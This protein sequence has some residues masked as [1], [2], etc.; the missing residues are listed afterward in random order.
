MRKI[1]ISTLDGTHSVATVQDGRLIEFS[2]EAESNRSIVGNVYKGRVVNVLNGMQA[3]FVDIGQARNAYLFVGESLVDSTALA[4][5]DDLEKSTALNVKP[6]DEIMVQVAKVATGLKGARVTA[7]VSLPGRNLVF[8]PFADYVGVSRKIENEEERNRLEE[9]MESL[10]PAGS[11]FIIRTAAEGIS[12][13]ELKSEAESLIAL[14]ERI[15]SKYDKI[16]CAQLAYEEGSILYRSVRDI[17]RSDVEEIIVDDEKTFRIVNAIMD[18]LVGKTRC[19]ITLEK[20]DTEDL[21]SKYGVMQQMLS[22]LSPKVVLS[23]GAYLI[24]ERTEALTVIDVNTGKYVGNKNLEETVFATNL[25][26][27]KEIAAQLRLRNIG[28]IIIVDFIDMENEEHKEQVLAKLAE[29]LKKDRIRTSLVGMTGLGLV[30]ITRKKARADLLERLAMKCPHC[31]GSSYVMS[32]SLIANTLRVNLMQH[33]ATCRDQ[34][35]I[36]TLNKDFLEYCT[37]QRPLKTFSEGVWRDK[38]IY[39][40]PSKFLSV[41]EF[42]IESNNDDVLELPD[43][44]VLMC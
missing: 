44:A 29:E 36:V 32:F 22:A 5:G 20:S 6:G 41:E 39:M 17:Y 35:V 7:N 3:A 24:I 16:K 31:H 27:A 14:W 11:G 4:D 34:N 37:K 13:R 30:E 23:N 9:I 15:L 43:N 28:G 40:I 33:F 38:R 19:K 12:K 18:E 26:A 2:V 42:K 25:L 10:R 1:Y 21:F 8:M